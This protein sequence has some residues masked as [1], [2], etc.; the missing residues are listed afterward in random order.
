MEDANAR[1]TL[2]GDTW[3]LQLSNPFNRT[4][5]ITRRVK[6]QNAADISIRRKWL[7]TD[8]DVLRSALIREAG[9]RRRAECRANM[10]TEVV[11]LALD[12]LVRE[13]DIEGFFGALSKT[14]VEESESHTC[15]VWLIEEGAQRCEL[16]MAFVK[17]RLFTPKGGAEAPE[18]CSGKQTFP[19]ESMA[20]HLFEYR[21]GWNQT[22][23]YKGDDQ[24][25]PAP[26]REFSRQLEWDEIVATPLVLGQRNLGW[27]TVSSPRASEPESRWWRV[28]LIEAIARQAALALH[29]NRLIELNRLE[30]RRKG[31]L[32]ERNRVARDI[33]DNLAQGFAAIL[34]QLQAAQREV[35]APAPPSPPGS[36]PRSIWRAHT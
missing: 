22:I 10:Q 15:A 19:C 27:M 5:D 14:M 9:E 13:P 2:R 4:S 11:R 20:S 26:V 16:W 1:S 24:R 21:Q 17:D 23:E 32:E 18:P 8:P 12:L 29:H 6:P 28:V 31:I 7:S 36:R 25:L 3:E 34:M 33:H 35:G 30:E